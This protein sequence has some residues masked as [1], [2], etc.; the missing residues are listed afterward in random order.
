MFDVL[1]YTSMFEKSKGMNNVAL[2]S[3]NMSDLPI[4]IVNDTSTYNNTL[5]Y[6]VVNNMH[7]GDC[8]VLFPKDLVFTWISDTSLLSCIM[9][10]ILTF[11]HNNG[12]ET[13]YMDGNDVMLNGCKLFGIMSGKLDDKY[14]E[15]MFLSFY[16]DLDIIKLVCK[17]PMTKI[18]VRLPERLYSDIL[19]LI[20]ELCKK[21]KLQ[22][23]GGDS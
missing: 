5:N 1:E 14:Y 23:Y 18:P 17:K 21:Y 2:F 4:L 12:L 11:L 6:E 22:I 8:I 15:G 9:L 10:D 7:K 3:Q 16:T 13:V 20:H 19:D